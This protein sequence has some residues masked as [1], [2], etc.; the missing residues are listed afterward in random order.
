MIKFLDLYKVNQQYELEIKEAIN[1]VLD[2]G[3]YILG[4]ADQRFEQNYAA[5]CGT[6]HCIGVANGLDALTLIFR[7]Y[8]ELEMMKD[9][10]EILVPANTYIASILSISENG[11]VPVLAG[12][13]KLF[14]RD[15]DKCLYFKVLRDEKAFT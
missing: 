6:K 5:Y 2:R 11:L 7:A 14:V 1:G 3:W 12:V 4:E 8:K 9:G 10:D 15:S 13:Y